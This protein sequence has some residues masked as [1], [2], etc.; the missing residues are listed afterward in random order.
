MEH[1]LGAIF[2]IHGKKLKSDMICS[3]YEARIAETMASYT[4]CV[5]AKS[6]VHWSYEGCKKKNIPKKTT[7]RTLDDLLMSENKKHRKASRKL[8]GG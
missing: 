6:C 8:N 5:C 4:N 7:P 3:G 2:E 1:K